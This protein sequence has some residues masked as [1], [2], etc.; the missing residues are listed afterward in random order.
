MTRIKL[1]KVVSGMSQIKVSMYPDGGLSRLGLFGENVPNSDAYA[2]PD[3][4]KSI[5]FPDP[6]PHANKPLTPKIQFS[7]EQVSK[8]WGVLEKGIEFDV[9]NL[10]YGGKVIHASNEHYGP[11]AQIISS[12]P[13]LNMFD[14]FESA[15]SRIAGHHEEVTIALGKP[16]LIHRI[17]IDFSFFR[18]NNPN[19]LKIEG[20]GKDWITLVERTHV[21]KHAGNKI[22]FLI[23]NSELLQQI[24]VMIF[25]DGGINRVRV[26][27]RA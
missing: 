3:S 20:L 6:V 23:K 27:S 19:D 18:N 15:R 10:A 12:Y 16:S 14:G 7:K 24:K 26:F 11:A 22:S 5:V 17:E 9:A 1:P 8:N 13:P 4:A 2:L 25:P 21:K